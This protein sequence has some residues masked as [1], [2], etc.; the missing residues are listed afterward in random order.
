[1]KKSGDSRNL[2]RLKKSPGISSAGVGNPI[3]EA[4]WIGSCP[5]IRG[6]PGIAG[7]PGAGTW[8]GHGGWPWIGDWPLSHG[9]LYVLRRINAGF[10]KLDMRE[11][12]EKLMT[13]TMIM[14][15]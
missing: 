13:M 2:H 3:C 5:E 12:K 7:M 15:K 4:A 9:L 10:A 14:N 6:W 8:P 11:R 1:M